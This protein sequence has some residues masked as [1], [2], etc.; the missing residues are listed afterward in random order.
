MFWLSFHLRERTCNGSWKTQIS[1]INKEQE[2]KRQVA[3]KAR[4]SCK[5]FRERTWLLQSWMWLAS[6]YDEKTADCTLVTDQEKRQNRKQRKGVYD[7]IINRTSLSLVFMLTII[8]FKDFII[9]RTKIWS[10]L[11]VSFFFSL[12]C[13]FF[14]FS[15]S[16]CL[17][18][19]FREL[20]PSTP[21]KYVA[22]NGG[23]KRF[24][25][26]R[27][28]TSKKRQGKSWNNVTSD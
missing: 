7:H 21:R 22:T 6:R 5:N 11:L 14:D 16:V 25:Q 18:L 3:I 8:S 1:Q 20:V 4:N 19:Y 28:W 13:Y 27:M 17:F 9:F 24:L 2:N 26:T 10:G 12:I 15:L 23:R